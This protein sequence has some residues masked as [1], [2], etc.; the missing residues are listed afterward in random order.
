MEHKM[1]EQ[2]IIEFVAKIHHYEEIPSGNWQS[3]YFR[4]PQDIEALKKSFEKLG[5]RVMHSWVSKDGYLAFDLDYNYASQKEKEVID[6]LM[7]KYDRM[8]ALNVLCRKGGLKITDAE[9]SY[10]AN[11]DAEYAK[12]KAKM[13]ARDVSQNIK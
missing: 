2:E 10:F 8:Q 6:D 1:T 13:A 12:I 9:Q 5:L 7:C 11:Q 3:M 4:G